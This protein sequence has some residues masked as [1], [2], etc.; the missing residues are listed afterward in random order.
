MNGGGKNPAC[1][2]D[3]QNVTVRLGR[4][5][6]S[7]LSRV[8]LPGVC[9]SGGILDQCRGNLDSGIDGFRANHPGETGTAM[10]N[11]Q[12]M[13]SRSAQLRA[14]GF[15]RSCH[16]RFTSSSPIRLSL[17]VAGRSS[18]DPGRCLETT[19]VSR[20]DGP[21]APG[22]P[23]GWRPG[24]GARRCAGRLADGGPRGPAGAWAGGK[25]RE[26]VHAADCLPA[27]W[28][29][30]A[31]LSPGSADLW[32][33]VDHRPAGLPLRPVGRCA[34]RSLAT[35]GVVSWF[36]A[37]PAGV[38][39]GREH[40]PQDGGGRSR[41]ESAGSRIGLRRVSS[42]RIAPLCPTPPAGDW[43]DVRPVL[44]QVVA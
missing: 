16:V 9:A 6:A 30:G 35:V 18:S 14:D 29:G 2:S 33:G 44:R 43:K 32:G 8:A 36:S 12:R 22:L 34:D 42:H 40:R 20:R 23:G 19:T 1:L 41:P 31:D 26:P 37:G 4:H 21:P 25:S 38:L 17:A 3:S 7:R 10:W 27:Q 11:W 28:S 15:P 24:G 5:S 13:R 39:H